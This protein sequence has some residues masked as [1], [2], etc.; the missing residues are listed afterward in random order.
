MLQRGEE[1]ATIWR[2]RCGSGRGRQAWGGESEVRAGYLVV[3]C[4]LRNLAAPR[5]CRQADGRE[6]RVRRQGRHCPAVGGTRPP[7]TAAAAARSV[8]AQHSELC[9]LYDG[10]RSLTT[11]ARG[12]SAQDMHAPDGWRA[13]GLTRSSAR[14]DDKAGKRR[15]RQRRKAHATP[16][17]PRRR[18]ACAS[19]GQG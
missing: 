2:V 7:W 15:A 5:V 10:P 18:A 12:V 14:L 19:M 13:C 17:A 3:S 9:S 16:A 11:R 6:P 8:R 4:K 1:A